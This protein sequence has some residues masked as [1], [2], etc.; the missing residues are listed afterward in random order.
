MIVMVTRDTTGCEIDRENFED[1]DHLEAVLTD[2]S[3]EAYTDEVVTGLRA[4]GYVT[5]PNGDFVDTY[6]SV[7]GE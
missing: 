7:D 1:I 4:V 3:T 6:Y 5:I 2:D